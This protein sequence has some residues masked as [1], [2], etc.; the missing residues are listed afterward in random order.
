VAVADPRILPCAR[1]AIERYGWQDATLERIAAEA[2]LSRMTL[3]RR[4]V[5]RHGIL[6]ALASSI[7]EQYR[8]AL[9]PALTAP[10]DARA[11]LE[12]ALEA[13]CD[14][15]EENLAL[16]AALSDRPRNA[17]FHED[18]EPGAGG[19]LTRR[20]FTEPVERLLR[21]GAADGSLRAVDDPAETA[22][23]L[24]NLISWTYRHLRGA[25]DWSPERT[26]RGVLSI[27]LEGIA[28]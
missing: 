8:A 18:S 13:L 28:A 14:V 4:G 26:R 15:V 3:H 11:R 2:G 25:H 5:T 10:G 27:A 24:F 20:T 16:V 22:T 1:R 7:E 6:S 17:I 12:Q 23:V 9:W 21:D 19:A